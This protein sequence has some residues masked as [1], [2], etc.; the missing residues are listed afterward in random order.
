MR[1]LTVLMQR[2][3][4]IRQE[5]LQRLYRRTR[6]RACWSMCSMN[7]STLG[8]TLGLTVAMPPDLLIGPERDKQR[9]Q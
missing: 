1:S 2:K 4:C 9:T 3:N 7:T 8:C 6:M 5:A